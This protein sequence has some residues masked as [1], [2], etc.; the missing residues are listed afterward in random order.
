M[1]T[2]VIFDEGLVRRYYKDQFIKKVL[3]LII[4]VLTVGSTG[5]SLYILQSQIVQGVALEV[6]AIF[7]SV[8]LFLMD[9]MNMKK[10]INNLGNEK[11]EYIFNFNDETLD[12]KEPNGDN[13]ISYALLQVKPL[14]S[15]FTFT[16]QGI[17]EKEFYIIPKSN[18]SYD[19]WLNISL[20][21]KKQKEDKKC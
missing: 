16:K 9:R 3:W 7:L 19:E 13:S 18:F 6:I 17:N 8:S 15:F 1:E 11:R 21:I 4:L 5:A 10:V 2:K 12:I 20:N 14:G